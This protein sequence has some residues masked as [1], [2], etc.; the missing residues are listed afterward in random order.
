M[1][2]FAFLQRWA[3]YAWTNLA[4]SIRVWAA[5]G[6]F[7]AG[8]GKSKNKTSGASINIKTQPQFLFSSLRFSTKANIA[9][10]RCLIAARLFSACCE[11]D[12]NWLSHSKSRGSRNAELNMKAWSKYW[13]PFC[14]ANMIYGLCVFCCEWEFQPGGSSS[15]TLCPLCPSSGSSNAT[16]LLN[17]HSFSLSLSL[18]LSLL[19]RLWVGPIHDSLPSYPPPPL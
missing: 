1:S 11:T 6:A 2:V 12:R 9:L 7:W 18:S 8:G 14:W 16:T 15:N 13:K 3:V 10:L 17:P 4:I 5:F 19:H